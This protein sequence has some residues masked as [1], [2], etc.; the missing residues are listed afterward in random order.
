[1]VATNHAKDSRIA[2]GKN[3]AGDA[4]GHLE[5]GARIQLQPSGRDPNR[6]IAKKIACRR[7]TV[8][9]LAALERAQHGLRWRK[10][11]NGR[12]RKML[13]R[14]L[15]ATDRPGIGLMHP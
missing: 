12:N 13:I 1:M 4:E 15:V 7:T 11:W 3:T 2:H 5:P 10:I 8:T 14:V 9:K 6:G